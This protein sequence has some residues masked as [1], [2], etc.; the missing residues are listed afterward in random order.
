MLRFKPCAI[1]SINRVE[2]LRIFPITK[3]KDIPV[4][5]LRTSLF[6]PHTTWQIG[7]VYSDQNDMYLCN[8][9][10]LVLSNLGM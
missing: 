6:A 10:L 4:S 5:V 9:L 2:L 8:N 1:D 7:R 3:L